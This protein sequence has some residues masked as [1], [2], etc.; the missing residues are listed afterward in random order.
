[1]TIL[2]DT[3][4]CI[5]II[6]GNPLPLGGHPEASFVTSWISGFEI[7]SGLRGQQASRSETRAR[8]FLEASQLQVFDAAAAAEAAKVRVYLEQ[9]GQRIGAYDTLIAGHAIAMEVP[10][11]TRNISEFKLVPSLRVLTW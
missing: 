5:E 4:A 6:R 8:A 9:A 2:M 11:L 7:L 10:L 1:M 3:D